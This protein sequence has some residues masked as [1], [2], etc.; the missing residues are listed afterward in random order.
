MPETGKK[1]DDNMTNESLLIQLILDI[2]LNLAG[3]LISL[4]LTVKLLLNKKKQKEQT[5]FF[6]MCIVCLLIA[7]IMA[8]AN[9]SVFLP[10]STEYLYFICQPLVNILTFLLVAQWLLFVDYTLHQSM[11]LIRRR[12]PVMRIPFFAAIIMELIYSVIALPQIVN[13]EFR[14]VMSVLSVLEGLMM[15]IFAVAAYIVLF[16]E[17]RR[18][19]VPRYIKLTP[20]ILCF[21]VVIVII[22][23]QF[24]QLSMLSFFCALGMLFA[25]Y[26]M[27]RRF[28]FMD[29]QTGFF[30][31]KYLPEFYKTLQKKELHGGTIIRFR[32]SPE[33]SEQAAEVL[34][35][36]EPEG[37]KIVTMGN[38]EFLI[39]SDPLKNVITKQLISFIDGQLKEEGITAESD[40]TTKT[41][42][43]AESFFRSALIPS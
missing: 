10:V 31:E 11:D 5:M 28:S 14:I 27:F 3:L 13:E 33:Q 6:R 2:V 21:A 39:L 12:Y 38:G 16:R 29:P 17:M 26:Y 22:A 36:W 24:Q 20:T 35:A 19:P 34:K 40:F 1:K 15:A 37:K 25:Y 43:S 23:G 42:G 4:F 32:V 9:I 8:V 7:L 18:T 30:T 41:D